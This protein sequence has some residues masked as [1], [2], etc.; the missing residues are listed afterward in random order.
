[1]P[2]ETSMEEHSR[3]QEAEHK[4]PERQEAIMMEGRVEQESAAEQSIQ[5]IELPTARI[6]ELQELL[7]MSKEL[8]KEVQR[9]VE[10]L[11]SAKNHKRV[12]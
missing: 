9:L 10:A 4:A 5:E 8:K 11:N 12:N 6:S 1:M 2:E 3:L 7:E